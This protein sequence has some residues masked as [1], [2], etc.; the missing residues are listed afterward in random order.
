MKVV[1]YSFAS[2][3]YKVVAYMYVNIRITKFLQAP[4]FSLLDCSLIRSHFPALQTRRDVSGVH[5]FP[6]NKRALQCAQCGRYFQSLS[7]LELHENLHKGLYRYKCHICG[8]GFSGTTNLRG[9]I[10]QHTGIKEFRCSFCS[11][12]YS[13]AYELRR[14][15]RKHHVSTE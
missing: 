14:H 7:G 1:G 2:D 12:E 8:R 11:K 15:V 3:T 10:V 13:Y 6:E 9:H 5:V 4:S